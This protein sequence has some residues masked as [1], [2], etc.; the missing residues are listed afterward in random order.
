MRPITSDDNYKTP[1]FG[2]KQHKSTDLHI[3]EYMWMIHYLQDKALSET[4]ELQIKGRMT[5]SIQ[6]HICHE[7]A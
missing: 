2:E 6:Q 4:L 3:S 5:F 7:S 1:M